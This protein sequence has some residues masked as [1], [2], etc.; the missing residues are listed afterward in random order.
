MIL[1]TRLEKGEGASAEDRSARPL[2]LLVHGK[3]GHLDIMQ[4]FLRSLPKEA[5]KLFIQAP[6]Q[7]KRGG[8]SW[9]D[10]DADP[11]PQESFRQAQQALCETVQQVENEQRLKPPYR[12]ALG[13]SQGS[14]M[15]SSLVLSGK[16]SLQKLAILAG[17]VK[18]PENPL[19]ATAPHAYPAFFWGHGENDEIVPID[20][21]ERDRSRLQGLG[22]SVQFVADPVGHKLGTRAMRSLREFF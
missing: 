9:W 17:F 15:L 11:F 1:Q 6:Y 10:T 3:A 21:A 20:R 14:A 18:W 7:D 2:I 16:L 8:W 13:F 12:S 4:I 22:Y 19:P 5:N